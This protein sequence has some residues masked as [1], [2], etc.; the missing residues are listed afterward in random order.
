ML[1]RLLLGLQQPFVLVFL[2][3]T[4]LL[5]LLVS[6]CYCRLAVSPFTS[7]FPSII[8]AIFSGKKVATNQAMS[9]G[10]PHHGKLSANSLSD[11]TPFSKCKNSIKYLLQFMGN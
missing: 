5:V 11:F 3:S 2:L 7:Q 8:L 4:A 1:D 10:R 9:W 6:F